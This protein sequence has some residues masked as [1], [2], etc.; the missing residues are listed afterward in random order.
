[1]E[2]TYT[3]KVKFRLVIEG[4]YSCC[5]MWEE[6]LWEEPEQVHDSLLE[7]VG[8]NIIDYLNDNNYKLEISDIQTEE[9]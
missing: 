1:M 3:Q 7:Y 5:N 9:D 6:E 2:K 8:D 4:E